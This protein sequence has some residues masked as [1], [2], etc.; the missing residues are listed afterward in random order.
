M[1]KIGT[2]P[3]YDSSKTGNR[4]PQ[5]LGFLNAHCGDLR[6]SLAAN[7]LVRS[8][9]NSNSSKILCISSFPASL[10]KDQINSNQENAMTSIF[11]RSME[12]IE[13]Q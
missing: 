13:K 1:A 10:K 5:L 7:S 9:R 6:C 12:V 11:R 4:E 8:G 3:R 2:H